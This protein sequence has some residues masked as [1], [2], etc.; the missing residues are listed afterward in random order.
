MIHRFKSALLRTEAL[1]KLRHVAQH[2]K[3]SVCLCLLNMLKP[4][5]VKLEFLGDSEA[6]VLGVFTPVYRAADW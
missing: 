4:P 1:A 2:Y 3:L 5:N 6:S